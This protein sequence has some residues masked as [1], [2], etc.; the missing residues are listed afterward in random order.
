MPLPVYSEHQ[1]DS[2]FRKAE[3]LYDE[4]EALLAQQDEEGARKKFEEAADLLKACNEDAGLKI[5][6]QAISN[7]R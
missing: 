2:R 6:Q 7:L 1:N 4:G 3:K 5:V